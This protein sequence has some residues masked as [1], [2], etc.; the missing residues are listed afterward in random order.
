MARRWFEPEWKLTAFEGHFSCT[1]WVDT[2]NSGKRAFRPVTREGTKI[3]FKMSTKL[4]NLWREAP[5]DGENFATH[6]EPFVA[7]AVSSPSTSSDPQ[8]HFSCPE[9]IVSGSCVQTF[10]PGIDW[11]GAL[12]TH[13]QSTPNEACF[14]EKSRNFLFVKKSIS[15]KL[16]LDFSVIFFI[17]IFATYKSTSLEKTRVIRRGKNSAHRKKVSEESAHKFSSIS[18]REFIFTTKSRK[19]K[20]LASL[21]QNLCDLCQQPRGP[22]AE[23]IAKHRIND[24]FRCGSAA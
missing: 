23:C 1:A 13:F 3:Y 9:K 14:T 11:F 10:L 16:K 18:D 7:F 8:F 4:H 15:R 24:V 19:R 5:D 20:K 17:V 21:S 6:A 12:C 2:T 22:D